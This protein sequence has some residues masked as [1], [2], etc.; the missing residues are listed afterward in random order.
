MAE[1]HD[2]TKPAST[3]TIAI[4]K[5]G[6]ISYF[7]IEHAGYLKPAMALCIHERRDGTFSLSIDEKWKS[8]IGEV[9]E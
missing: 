6:V 4:S 7:P 2:N 1:H 5:M 8:E 3:G 9:D